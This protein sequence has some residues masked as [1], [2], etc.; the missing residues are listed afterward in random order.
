MIFFVLFFSFFLSSFDCYSG[1]TPFPP[2]SPATW[3]VPLP[4]GVH[5]RYPMSSSIRAE[6]VLRETPPG[7]INAAFVLWAT[8]LDKVRAHS[9]MSLPQGFHVSIN[10]NAKPAS[11]FHLG[12]VF[13]CNL[14]FYGTNSERRTKTGQSPSPVFVSRSGHL[15]ISVDEKPWF[16]YFWMM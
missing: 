4:C 9:A 1:P 6:T 12:T 15:L 11:T 5:E 8:R 16:S 13:Q 10:I 2:D 14:I 3:P 7:T